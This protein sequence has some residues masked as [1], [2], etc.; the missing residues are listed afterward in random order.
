MMPGTGLA[1]DYGALQRFAWRFVLPVLRLVVPNVNSASRSGAAL[2]RL[3]LDPTLGTV[4]GRY[5][6]GFEE[7]RSSAASYDTAKAT[8]LWD[9]SAELVGV[10]AALPPSAHGSSHPGVG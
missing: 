1:R 9:V 7:I 4:S 10:A 5:F 3:V 2:A 6:E 8:A